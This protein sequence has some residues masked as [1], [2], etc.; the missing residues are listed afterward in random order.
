MTVRSDIGAE[1]LT[2]E[3][4]LARAL[5]LVPVL[6]GRAAQTEQLRRIPDETVG[7][8]LSSGLY[9]IG[10]PRRFGG[11]DVGY[12]LVLDVAAELGR[13]CASTAWCY[14]LWAAHAWLVGYWPRQAQEE[15]FRPS[16]D[17]L[18]SSSLNIGKSNTIPVE[19]G[20]RL[21]GRW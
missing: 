21:S 11:L 5:E 14:C 15:V 2:T 18:C 8:L 4:L 9:R 7:E 13:G 16:P 10:V 3:E 20:Y 1:M 19:G 6:K 12:G 17:V